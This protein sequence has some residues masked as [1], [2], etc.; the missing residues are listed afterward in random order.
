MELETIYIISGIYFIIS[1]LS[2]VILVLGE[3]APYGKFLKSNS[4][5]AINA[6]IAWCIQ[7]TPSLIIPICLLFSGAPKATQMPNIILILM[8][9]V[10]YIQRTCIYPLLIRGGKPFPLS[11]FLIA[12]CICTVNGYLQSYYI[13]YYGEYGE[14]WWKKPHFIIGLFLFIFGM[15]TNVYS[16][17]ILRN[18]RKPGE[19]GYKIP[20]GGMFTYVSGAN[21]FGEIVEWIGFAVATWSLPG[22]AFAAFTFSNLGPR[23]FHHHRYYKEKFEDYP[24]DRKALIPFLL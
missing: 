8:M 22:L 10:H 5:I 2:L 24:K 9:V 11:A 7:E 20:K 14:E 12:V 19:T 4:G 6:N 21:F 23:A 3:P 16:D 18:L 15:S 17:Q 13:L 1:V